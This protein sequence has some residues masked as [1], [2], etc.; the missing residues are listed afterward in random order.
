[1]T[2][3]LEASPGGQPAGWEEWCARLAKLNDMRVDL[4]RGTGSAH[5]CIHTR[6]GGPWAGTFQKLYFRHIIYIDIDIYIYGTPPPKIH[7]FLS[8]LS[9]SCAIPA[10]LFFMSSVC[11]SSRVNT[12]TFSKHTHTYTHRHVHK[13]RETWRYCDPD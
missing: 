11:L 2:I 9:S 7:A 8:V 4:S 12:P 10:C 3:L 1:M 13:V 6:N 5:I